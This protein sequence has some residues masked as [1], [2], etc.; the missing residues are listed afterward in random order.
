MLH[1]A[2]SI[3]LLL[4]VLLVA[5]CAFGQNQ[6]IVPAVAATVVASSQT[7]KTQKRPPQPDTDQ[8][9]GAPYWTAEPGWH[10]ALESRGHK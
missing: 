1:K 8:M 6:S 2:S 4:M 10:T 5:L 9:V 3:A 7:R